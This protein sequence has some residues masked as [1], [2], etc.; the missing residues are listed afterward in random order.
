MRGIETKMDVQG[1]S[2]REKATSRSSSDKTFSTRRKIIMAAANH[3]VPNRLM[4]SFSSVLVNHLD[5]PTRKRKAEKKDVLGEEITRILN[6]EP[7]F[8][9]LGYFDEQDHGVE[10][11][12]DDEYSFKPLLSAKNFRF[13]KRKLMS[14]AMLPFWPRNQ[15]RAPTQKR[16]QFLGN[17]KTRIWSLIVLFGLSF[18]CLTCSAAAISLCVLWSLKFLWI[19]CSIVVSVLVDTH[20]IYQMVPLKLREHLSN[21]FQFLIWIDQIILLGRRYRGR[22]WNKENFVLNNPQL[23]TSRRS[24]LWSCPPPSSRDKGSS[25]HQQYIDSSKWGQYTSQHI[26]AIDYCYGMLRE[27]FLRKQYSKLR[28]SVLGKNISSPTSTSAKNGETI[29]Y[30]RRL[31]SELASITD[32]QGVGAMDEHLASNSDFYTPLGID[33]T[34]L[35]ATRSP[36]DAI[37]VIRE[38]SQFFAEDDPN[39]IRENSSTCFSPH[40]NAYSTIDSLLEVELTESTVSSPHARLSAIDSSSDA[41]NDLNW[42]DVGAE[43]GMKLLRSSAVQKAIASQDTAAQINT[44]K[45]KM[46]GK[47]VKRKQSSPTLDLDTRDDFARIPEDEKYTLPSVPQRKTPTAPCHP[48][49]TSASAAAQNSLALSPTRTRDSA[50]ISNKC[51]SPT[52]RNLEGLVNPTTTS[53]TPDQHRLLLVYDSRTAECKKMQES[54]PA[55]RSSLPTTGDGDSDANGTQRLH[56]SLHPSSFSQRNV[57][58]PPARATIPATS[59][60]VESI[61]VVCDKKP[62]GMP[63]PLRK[64]VIRRQALLPGVKIAVPI[65][66]LQPGVRLS[67]RCLDSNFQMGTVI[68]SKRI[69][70]GTRSQWVRRQHGATNC[71]SI[72]VALDKS[73]LRDGKFSELTIRVFDEWDKRFMPKH[74]KLPL[75]SCVATSFGPGVLVGW[76]VED[77]MHAVRSLW[78]RRGR[79]SACAY[80]N[81]DAIHCTIEAAVGFDVETSLG[82]GEVVAFVGGAQDVNAGKF[83]ARI[84]DEGKYKDCTL[85]LDRT[86]IH[87]CRSACFIPVIEHIREAAKYQ[88]QVDNYA[89]ALEETEATAQEPKYGKGW[90]HLKAWRDFSKYFDILWSSFMKVIAEDEEFDEGMNE[91]IADVLNFLDRLDAPNNDAKRNEETNIVITATEST[92]VNKDK[93]VKDTNFWLLN[94]VFG[95]FTSAGYECEHDDSDLLPSESIE[96]ECSFEVSTGK[97]SYDKAYDVIRTLMKTVSIAK[98]SCVDD[99]NFKLAMSI[100]Y[101]FLLFTK[102]VLKVQQRNMSPHS[103]KVWRRAWDEIVSTFGP[104]KDRLEKIGQGIADRMQRQGK[105]AKV[106]LLRFV[107]IVVQDD[108]LLSSIERGEWEKCGEQVEMALVKSRILDDESREYYHKTALFLYNHFAMASASSGSA[109]ER[110][111]EKL[112]QLASAL[113]WMAAPKKFMLKLFLKDEFL[114][115]LERILVRVFQKEDIASRMLSIHSSNFKTLRQFR[116]LKDF[117][118][119]GKL[120]IPL[121]DAADA[122]FSWL[123]SQLPENTKDL[124]D[125]L[126]SLFSLC[127]LQFHKIDGGDLTKDWLDFLLEEEAVSIIHEIDMKLILALESFSRDVKEMMVVLPYYPR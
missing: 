121:L 27:A 48:M 55:T 10:E 45:E 118:V 5:E 17:T 21:L 39:E 116:M 127:I 52:T 110:N 59:R 104:V 31:N 71:L 44:I 97:T 53:L 86:D 34:S 69:F 114:D 84:K 13:L 88:L 6:E 95:I 74:S 51:L 98:A 76:R 4:E 40:D 89:E 123:V 94:D 15:Q 103:L 14:C 117:T 43:I 87:A 24:D 101:E 91:F 115:M 22:E 23:A 47:L 90:R 83:Y 32:S 112:E 108:I 29:A 100:C 75:G 35:S 46:E 79:G 30:T 122:E 25:I 62:A 7:M 36:T 8:C 66:P 124:M 77:D 65:L 26:G 50:T 72:T 111:N 99:P 82:Q 19:V 42:M 92:N 63:P 78:Q 119:A 106:R 107:D 54:P 93:A 113:Q 41:T 18:L 96:V 73:F 60:N 120:W 58:N 12:A 3:T 56:F 125:S 16:R 81:R 126:S 105:R 11:G 20:D 70:V 64:N 2:R 85:E 33:G 67:K 80:L 68:S 102:T 61:E 49:W 38:R 109:A 37:E 1:S 9:Q 28:K 57:F